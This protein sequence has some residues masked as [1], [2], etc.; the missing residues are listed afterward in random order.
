MTLN[1]IKKSSIFRFISETIGEL[2][3]V[4]WLS[5]PEIT[6]LTFLVLIVAIVSG[7]VLGAVDYGFTQLVN[8]VFVGR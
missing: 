7:L 4:H 2:K 1:I 8:E 3:K 5:K 6:Y